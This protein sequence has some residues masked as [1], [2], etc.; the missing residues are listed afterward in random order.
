MLPA[1][2]LGHPDHVWILQPVTRRGLASPDDGVMQEHCANDSKD[3]REI[4]PPHPADSNRADV[5]GYT[6]LHVHLGESELLRNSLVALAAGNI[7]IGA[8]D[9]GM[10]IARWQ[11]VMHSVATGAVCHHDGAAFRSHPVITVKI[12]RYSVSL[13]A[14]F[15]RKPN[16]FMTVR[17]GGAGQVLLGDR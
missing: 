9:G 2:V 10:R 16:S 13:Y 3:Q 7:E 1:L 6:D 4:E 14:E 8:V 12:T 17:A 5:F 11:N 15:L